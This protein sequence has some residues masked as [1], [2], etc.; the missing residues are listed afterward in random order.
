M[1]DSVDDPGQR[2]TI[3]CEPLNPTGTHQTQFATRSRTMRASLLVALAGL[4]LAQASQPQKVVF[5][6]VFPQ[7]GQIG[8]FIAA[9]DGSNE[10]P[11][12]TPADIDYDAAWAPDGASIVFTSERNGSAD[13]YRVRPDG[14]GLERLTDSPA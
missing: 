6:R 14:S 12:V 8:L 1:V 9:A 3:G 5:S 4:A 10:H 7:P 11:L 2:L 13:L